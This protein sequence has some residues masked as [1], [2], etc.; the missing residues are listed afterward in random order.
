MQ[1]V[2]YTLLILWIA[3][4]LAWIVA[5]V[6]RKTGRRTRSR[7]PA[8]ANGTAAATAAS[9]TNGAV[10]VA[11]TPPPAR[12]S[13]ASRLPSHPM[14]TASPPP[15]AAA[16]APVPAAVP[17]VVPA[18]ESAPSPVPEPMP[19][20]AA[21]PQPPVAAAE[22]PATTPD[23]TLADLLGGITVPSE[24]VPVSVGDGRENPYAATLLSRGLEAHVVGTEIADELERLGYELLPIAETELLAKRGDDLVTVSIDLEP[25]RPDASGHQRVASAVEG[26]IVIDFWVGAGPR[27][28]GADTEA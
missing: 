28:G 5:Q 1:T 4:T 16:P 27:P 11:P 8:T 18:A 19:E 23:K 14:P 2:V 26:D 3:L 25:H 21:A 20:P 6:V 10:T 7:R 12:P 13:V 22:R 9:A 17:P 24:V 15:A